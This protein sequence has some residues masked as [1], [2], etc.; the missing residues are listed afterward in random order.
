MDW[1]AGYASDI[2]YVAGFYREQSPVFLNFV[3]LLYGNEPVPLDRPYTYFE[4][5]F[6]RGLTLNA[7]AAANPM[8]QFYGADF[9]PSHVAGAH[10][11]AQQADLKNIVLLED[12]FEELAQGKRDLPQFDFVTL[13]GIYTW[14]T[15][16]NQ[17]HIVEFL[18]RYLKPGGIVYLSY[19]AMPGWAGA[20]PLQRL[21]T[22]YGDAHPERSDIQVRGAAQL[23]SRMVELQANYFVANPGLEVRLKSLKEGSVNYL[24]HEYM[25]KHW[26]PRFHADVARDLAGAK[27]EFAGSADLPLAYPQ[28][29]LTPEKQEV[30]KVMTSAPMRETMKDYFLNTAFR[31]D[32]FIRGLRKL[33]AARRSA[34]LESLTLT[35]TV[36]RARASGVLNASF[37]TINGRAEIYEAVFNALAEKPHTLGQLRALPA[38]Q[39]VSLIDLT[40][41][42]ALL[43][44]TNQA[45]VSFPANIAASPDAAQKFN[46]AIAAATAQGE[47]WAAFACP[48]TGN[49][50]ATSQVE[51]MVYHVLPKGAGP[52]DATQ[53]TKA[54]WAIFKA[55]GRA[56][57]KDGAAVVGD[58]ENLAVLQP[59]VQGVLDNSLPTWK[60]LRMI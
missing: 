2:E 37:G 9:N 27:L 40:Q 59:Q 56:M 20:L 60:K 44:G 8:G 55:Q 34:M 5:G 49:G 32:V 28:L 22:E 41:T 15:A 17:R 36:P 11:L 4:L 42:A 21:L 23:V 52:V 29:Y 51:R 43:M 14:V 10:Q 39:H 3:S 47:E 18:R 7:I 12:S 35:L 58:E 45:E 54:V 57:L 31:K 53:V 50:T 1:T 25:H 33:P 6:G 26:E 38:L 16:E 48:D 13:H 19:N 24:V 46:A 30:L